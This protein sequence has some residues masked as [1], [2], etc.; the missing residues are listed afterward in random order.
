MLSPPISCNNSGDMR[1]RRLTRRRYRARETRVGRMVNVADRTVMGARNWLQCASIRPRG[2]L[3]WPQ[4]LR[5]LGAII[6]QMGV[7]AL[8]ILW[9]FGNG[10]SFDETRMTWLI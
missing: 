2:C 5:T 1:S 7:N 10:C 8:L 9:L 6:G 4:T 3:K